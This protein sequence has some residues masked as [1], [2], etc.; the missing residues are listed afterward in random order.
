M[1]RCFKNVNLG[2]YVFNYETVLCASPLKTQEYYLD[3]LSGIHSIMVS[4]T[5]RYDGHVNM[6]FNFEVN[7]NAFI[8]K[9]YKD[10]FFG[11]LTKSYVY[12][13]VFFGLI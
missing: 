10:L 5:I 13:Q 9:R 2:I 4:L 3:L 7:H 11:C 1:K 12:Y 8:L 6:E